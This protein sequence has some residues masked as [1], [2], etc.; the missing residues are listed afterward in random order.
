L[1]KKLAYISNIPAPYTV[2]L[3]TALREFFDARAFFYE[4]ASGQRAAFWDMDLPHYCHIAGPLLWK[5]NGRFLTGQHLKWLQIFNPDVVVMSGFS[6]PANYLAYRWAKARGKK[7]IVLTEFSRTAAGEMR[8]KTWEW[9]LLT[10]LYKHVDAVFAVTPE[11]V[12]QFRD[13]FGFGEKVKAAR[14]ATDLDDYLPHPLR[15][16]GPDLT[17]LFANRLTDSYNPLLALKAFYQ[18]QQEFPQAK[19]LLNGEGPLRAA[20]QEFISQFQLKQVR[21]LDHLQHWNDLNI[22]YS[23]SDVLLLPAV[24]S[25][26]NFTIYEAMASGMGLVISEQVRGNGE[27]IVNNENGF[28]LPV[29]EHEMARAMKRYLTDPGLLSAHGE[30]NKKLVA[31]LGPKGTAQLYYQ[32][33]Q[34]L[35]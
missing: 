24:F 19:L 4:K 35:L 18:V 26:G 11:A 25:A 30:K 20:C 31:H 22:V 14:Y 7:V 23:Q 13:V 6:I 8:G 5:K 3:V 9:Q 34:T 32:L 16:T 1:K 2:R 21:F 28:R 27:V 29:E 33:I 17:F 10:R 12:M 15:Q